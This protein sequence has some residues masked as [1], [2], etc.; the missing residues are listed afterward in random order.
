MSCIIFSSTYTK[1]SKVDKIAK[2]LTESFESNLFKATYL[3]VGELDLPICD[4]YHCYQNPRVIEMQQQVSSASSFIFCSPVYNYD[5]NAVCKNLIE[6]FGQGLKDKVVGIAVVAGGE[7]SYMAP[8]G[9]IN[10]LMLD[11]RCVVMPRF[12]YATGTDF[13]NENNL[14]SDDIQKRIDQLV[15]SISKYTK[16]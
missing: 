9:F 2:K 15:S 6:L 10:S 12:I 3:N 5:V 4:G 16:E 11:F 7:K 14:I 8:M 1:T 13:D